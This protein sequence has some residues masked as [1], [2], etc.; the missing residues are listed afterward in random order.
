MALA[1]RARKREGQSLFL[2]KAFLGFLARTRGFLALLAFAYLLACFAC[3]VPFWGGGGR[4]DG[5]GKGGGRWERRNGDWER[6]RKGEGELE[7]SYLTYLSLFIS[8]QKI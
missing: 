1:R 2:E 5:I 3:S 7:A 6:R 4:G 8:L